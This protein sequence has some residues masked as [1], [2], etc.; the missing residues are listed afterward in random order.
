M[1]EWLLTLDKLLRL[2]DE[3]ESESELA[4]VCFL[5]FMTKLEYFRD[6]STREVAIAQLL[7]FAS[8]KLRK[9][10]GFKVDHGLDARLQPPVAA[11]PELERDVAAAAKALEGLPREAEVPWGIRPLTAGEVDAVE[12]TA[13][14]H[15]SILLQN[16]ILL[17]TIVPKPPSRAW[18]LKVRFP[19]QF[20]FISCQFRPMSI[21]FHFHFPNFRSSCI[22]VIL[23]D[24]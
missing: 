5:P 17:D 1:D 8:S 11:S 6:P 22:S 10:S 12:E 4:S 13:F 21:S 3:E 16:K 9:V 15:N 19:F 14:S 23:H 24:A 18:K 20:H 2:K 7:D